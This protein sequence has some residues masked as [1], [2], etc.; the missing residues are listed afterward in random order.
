[1]LP[2]LGRILRKLDD[3]F[4]LDSSSLLDEFNRKDEPSKFI[5][6]LLNEPDL[7]GLHDISPSCFQAIVFTWSRLP[8][9]NLGRGHSAVGQHS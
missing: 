2:E 7:P 9:I 1:M 5:P 4:P 8:L 3:V 6:D